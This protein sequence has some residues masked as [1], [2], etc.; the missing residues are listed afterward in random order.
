M[1]YVYIQVYVA[2]RKQVLALR[3]GYKHHY[4]NK[5][6]K[7][8]FPK[9]RLRQ[10]LTKKRPRTEKAAR[11]N[12]SSADEKSVT[13]LKNRRPSSDLITLRIHHGTYQNPSIESASRSNESDNESVNTIRRKRRQTNNF[14]RNFSKD[15]KAAKFI[16][17][18]MGVFVICW[19]P[20]FVYLILSGVFVV[21]LKDDQ[22]HELLFKIFSWLGYTNS[23]LDVVVYVSTSKELQATFLKLFIPRRFRSAHATY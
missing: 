14:W 19:L 22:N 13:L 21:R 4:R 6:A 15:Q 20:Y 9:F 1:I 23:A 3:S 18:I 12:E 2:A 11:I 17:V 7:S 16:G 5:S 10:T 8:C